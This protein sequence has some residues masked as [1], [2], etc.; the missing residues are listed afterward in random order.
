M[1]ATSLNQPPLS[2]RVADGRPCQ[3]VSDGQSSP[4]ADRL[5]HVFTLR[6]TQKLLT[7]LKAQPVEQ[8]GST[9]TVLGDWYANLVYAGRT[10]VVLAVSDR[11]L[12]PVVVPAREART[13]VQRLGNAVEPILLSIGVPPQVVAAERHAMQLVSLGKTADRRI[14]GSLKE[15]AFQLEVGLLSSPGKSLLE[16]S[17]WLAQ[18]PMKV[19][20]YGS[21]EDATLAAFAAHQAVT[22]AMR[23]KHDPG[24]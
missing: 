15:L 9:D 20:D 14:L 3:S 5:R 21:P 13:L 2:V 22:V 18:T 8:L 19:I 12:L 11:T 23:A 17:L 7:R 24:Q 6:C 10:Q 16:Q 4:L 1:A